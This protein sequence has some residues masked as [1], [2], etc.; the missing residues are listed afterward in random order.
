MQSKVDRHTV[1]I[2]DDDVDYLETVVEYA[3]KLGYNVLQARGGE[4]AFKI[5]K[6]RPVSG[7]IMDLR[8][9]NG[10]GIELLRKIRN[11]QKELP[12]V[13][14]IVVNTGVLNGGEGYLQALGARHVF[15]KPVKLKVLFDRLEE[16]LQSASV[17]H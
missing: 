7:M 3:Q 11:W 2:V 12:L 15:V 5:L 17:E 8:M 14:R 6:A 1:L 4:E 13:P 9:A 10:S 16:L